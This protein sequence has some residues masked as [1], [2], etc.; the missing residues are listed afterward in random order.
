MMRKRTAAAYL[1]L[2][3]AAFEREI[4]TGALPMGHHFGG[5]DSWSKKQ[6]DAA[7]DR[8]TGDAEYDWRKDTPL[9]RDNSM[10]VLLDKAKRGK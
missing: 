8:M 10:D 7:V 5:R 2:S 9:Y 6:I 1:D 3:I 4:A